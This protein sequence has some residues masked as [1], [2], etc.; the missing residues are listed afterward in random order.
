MEASTDEGL[1]CLYSFILILRIYRQYYKAMRAG[2]RIMQEKIIG[3][4]IGVFDTLSKQ[5]MLRSA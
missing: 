3:N 1:K 4:W 5:N 2:D